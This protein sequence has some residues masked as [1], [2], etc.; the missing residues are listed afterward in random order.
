MSS[1]EIVGLL[2][3]C[4]FVGGVVILL[5]FSLCFKHTPDEEETPEPEEEE[6]DSIETRG[7]LEEGKKNEAAD[8]HVHE[9]KEGVNEQELLKKLEDGQGEEKEEKQMETV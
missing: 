1:T 2:G 7:D 4:L 8:V 6:R 5:P 9:G 3:S